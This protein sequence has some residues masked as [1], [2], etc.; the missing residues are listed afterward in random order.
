MRLCILASWGLLIAL[1]S[2]VAAKQPRGSFVEAESRE[3][4]VSAARFID[5]G[6][7]PQDWAEFIER[8][9]NPFSNANHFFH[10]SIMDKR[11]GSHRDIPMIPAGRVGISPHSK[12]IA[13]LSVDYPTDG[14]VVVTPDGQLVF[15]MFGIC[16][17]ECFTVSDYVSAWFENQVGIAFSSNDSGEDCLLT[18][19]ADGR[20][21][22][23]PAMKVDVCRRTVDGVV[24]RDP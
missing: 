7:A 5:S 6:F 11:R 3:L 21:A 13:V 19:S 9:G 12:Y 24:R 14:V 16:F 17:Q 8:G 20:K 1:S 10:M 23:S 2:C 15:K 22:D 4:K 18:I